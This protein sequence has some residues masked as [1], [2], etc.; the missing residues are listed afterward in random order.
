MQPYNV[1]SD[2]SCS[3]A[4]D[5]VRELEDKEYLNN[6]LIFYNVTEPTT[7]RFKVDSAYISDLYRITFDLNVV[8][9]KS[10]HLEKKID[11]KHRPLLIRLGNYEIK[12]R[13]LSKSFILHHIRIYSCLQT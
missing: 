3:I 7:P 2:S 9:I 12:A 10:F 11:K 8:I 13:I 5:I 1:V 6:N 4:V